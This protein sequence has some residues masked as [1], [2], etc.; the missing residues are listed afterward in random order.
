MSFKIFRVRSDL[1]FLQTRKKKDLR[2]LISDPITSAYHQISFFQYQLLRYFQTGPKTA[3]DGVKFAFDKLDVEIDQ[4]NIEQFLEKMR[5]L[6]LLEPDYRTPFPPHKLVSVLSSLK[7]QVTQTLRKQWSKQ[8]SH[9]FEKE[10]TAKILFHMHS[11]DI[12]GALETAEKAHNDFPNSELLSRLYHMIRSRILNELRDKSAQKEHS[13]LVNRIDVYN[14][15]KL[16]DRLKPLIYAVYSPIGIGITIILFLIAINILWQ[17]R[18]FWFSWL[19]SISFLLHN[20]I[21]IFIVNI[22]SGI[23][24]EFGHASVCYRLGG[25]VRHMGLLFFLG[26]FPAMFADITDSYKM[27]PWKRALCSLGGV[28]VNL[29]LFTIGIFLWSITTPY[30]FLNTL[31]IVL[32]WGNAFKV[33]NNLSPTFKLDGYYVLT[34]LTGIENL[35]NRSFQYCWHKIKVLLIGERNPLPMKKPTSYEAMVFWSYVIA[36]ISIWGSWLLLGILTT[37]ALWQDQALIPKILMFLFLINISR[38]ASSAVIS[39]FKRMLSFIPNLPK[40]LRTSNS[41]EQFLK[42][43]II[44]LA[45]C[46]IFLLPV[47]YSIQAPSIIA[48]DNETIVRNRISGIINAVYVSEGE[49]VRK[50]QPLITISNPDLAARYQIEQWNLRQLSENLNKILSGLSKTEMKI[51][52]QKKEVGQARLAR[53]RN[54]IAAMLNA[55]RVGVISQEELL[56]AYSDLEREYQQYK[57][58]LAKNKTATAKPTLATIE[59]QRRKLEILQSKIREA[60]KDLQ[61]LQIISPINGVITTPTPNEL[62]GHY[63]NE[64]THLLTISSMNKRLEI[65]ANETEIADISLGMPLKFV[66]SIIGT[67]SQKGWIDYIPSP[68]EQINSKEAFSSNSEKKSFIAFPPPIKIRALG[69]LE[70]PQSQGLKLGSSG[71]TKIDAG[72]ST[73]GYVL[74]KNIWRVIK[75]NLWASF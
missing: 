41:R 30:T 28:F 66:S 1:I 53:E 15:D 51:Y 37:M 16:L 55:K 26:V 65:I 31:G 5:S 6:Q 24:H 59:I 54:R 27:T 17:G 58:L 50:N 71:N 21:L 48:S 14:P 25:K 9:E 57:L 68:M 7:E 46:F 35:Y 52:H 73:L 19:E 67:K 64:G 72:W 33:F 49:T 12:Y 20:F 70:K 75:V 3:A 32:V 10:I 45:I 8:A 63:V 11:Y 69:R 36:T 18:S 74:F 47:P 34:D 4:R 43:L 62:L 56:K 42:R 13:A 61:D 44:P 23:L 39:W 2:F 60:E 29:I 22:L 38:E 40:T